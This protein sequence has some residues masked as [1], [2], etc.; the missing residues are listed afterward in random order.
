M[1]EVLKYLLLVFLVVCA[2]FV[3]RTRDL[4]AA[5][6]IFAA[7]SLTMAILWLMLAA[8]DIAI[9]EAAMGAGVTTFLLVA[10]ISKTRR[11]E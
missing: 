6:I 9:T 3:A 8:P 7:Y 1:T 10:T 5:V 11:E 4:L 2:I